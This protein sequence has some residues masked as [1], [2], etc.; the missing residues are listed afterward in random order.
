MALAVTHVILTIILLDLVRHYVFKK[1]RF[2][3]Y[4]VIIGGIAGLA[5]DIDII[6][7]YIYNLFTTTQ[8]NFHGLYTHSVIFVILFLLLASLMRF[9]KNEKWEKIFYVVATGWFLHILLDCAFN[10][11]STFLWPININ[12]KILCPK[13]GLFNYRTG[14]DAIILVAWLIHEEVHNKIKDYF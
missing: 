7:N 1:K 14:I 6:F 9:R 13:N 4:L 10:P 11:Y 3:R 12:T 5:P 8:I 2:P